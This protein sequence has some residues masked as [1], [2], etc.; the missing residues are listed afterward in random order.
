MTSPEGSGCVGWA[1]AWAWPC[2]CDVD[3]D[4]AAVTTLGSDPADMLCACCGSAD[5]DTDRTGAM[6]TEVLPVCKELWCGASCLAWLLPLILG[7]CVE[8][9]CAAAA[10]VAASAAAAMAAPTAEDVDDDD[11]GAD[12]DDEDDDDELPG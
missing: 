10:D 6:P 1:W 3:C 9:G 7:L 8:D 4:C 2:A 11:D 5:A 12:D